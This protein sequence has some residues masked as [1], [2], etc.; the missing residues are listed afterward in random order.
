MLISLSTPTVPTDLAPLS[1]TID[2]KGQYAYV[3][4]FTAT[5]IS[6]YSIDSTTGELTSIGSPVLVGSSSGLDCVAV[7]PSSRFLYATH[8]NESRLYQF[9]INSGGSISSLPTP[10][11]ATGTNPGSVTT[12]PTGT[13]VYAGNSNSEFITAY[14]FDATGALTALNSPGISASGGNGP[15]YV[16][17]DPKGKFAYATHVNAYKISQYAIQSDGTLSP[18]L[19]PT[20]STSF[21]PYAIA[22]DSLGKFVYVT[23][24]K[25][26][27]SSTNVLVYSIDAGTGQLTAVGTPTAA[28]AAGTSTSFV[29]VTHAIY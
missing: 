1:I 26:S 10:S 18:L 3:A 7:D 19:T 25:A 9:K 27:D 8:Q 13:Y 6:A 2:P 29:A 4:N 24:I 15:A 14:S 21:K 17:V 5:K 11:V 20:I 12:N 22:V 28:G 16:A 23:G